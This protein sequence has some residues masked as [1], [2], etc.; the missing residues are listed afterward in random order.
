MAGVAEVGR[1]KDRMT[2]ELAHQMGRPVRYGGKFGGFEQRAN[3][4][5]T[6]A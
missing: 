5:A 4:M 1:P 3:Y 2:T 6:I